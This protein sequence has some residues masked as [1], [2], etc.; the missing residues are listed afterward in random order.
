MNIDLTPHA[1]FLLLTLTALV[2]FG[3]PSDS[4]YLHLNRLNLDLIYYLKKWSQ[5]HRAGNLIMVAVY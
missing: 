4:F 2:C 3:A 5:G 1:G